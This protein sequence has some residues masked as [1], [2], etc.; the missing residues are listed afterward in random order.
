[1]AD[2]PPPARG[3]QVDET[4]DEEEEHREEQVIKDKE[5]NNLVIPE[6]GH[7][8]KKYG[9]KFIKTIRK[10]RSYFKCH[11][12][13]CR[14]KKRVEWSTSKPKNI[15]I[16]YEG[17]HTHSPSTDPQKPASSQQESFSFSFEG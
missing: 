14:A 2:D 7:G 8:W 16:S 12:R 13:N 5:D 10:N 3:A 17:A 1:M 11:K 6:D 15:R 4:H 9:Q